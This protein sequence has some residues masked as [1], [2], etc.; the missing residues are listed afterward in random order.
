M[1]T[2]I[3]IVTIA[4]VAVTQ[5]LPVAVPPRCVPNRFDTAGIGSRPRM[6]TVSTKKKTLQM[7]LMKRSVCSCSAG[8]ATSLRR[9]SHTASSTFAAPVG[10]IASTPLVPRRRFT[11]TGTSAISS[12]PASAIIAI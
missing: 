2:I 8:S 10:T 12:T 3:T 5:M 6:L 9:Y 7:Y 11:S 1:I 4:S